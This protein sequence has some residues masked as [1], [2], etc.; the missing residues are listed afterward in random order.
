M[1]VSLCHFSSEASNYFACFQFSGASTTKSCKNFALMIFVM[2]V[3][4]SA[5]KNLR[6]TE[7]NF[8]RFDTGELY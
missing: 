7:W 8:M 5:S 6:I 3:C 1:R 4:L 2:F